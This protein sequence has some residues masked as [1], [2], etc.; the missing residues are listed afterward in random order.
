MIRI[1]P[2]RDAIC[3]HGIDCPFAVDRYNCRPDAREFAVK[4]A[5][6]DTQR[7][8]ERAATESS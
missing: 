1:C 6:R 5:L 7:A 2:K 8:M 4:A 3:P